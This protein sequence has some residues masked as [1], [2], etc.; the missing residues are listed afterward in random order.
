T[1]VLAGKEWK[2]GKSKQNTFNVNARITMQGGE[3]YAPFDI[4][5]TTVKQQIVYDETKA[6]TKQTAPLM[7]VHLTVAYKKNKLK[8]SREL[9]LKIVNLTQQ[10]DFY[11]YQYNFRTGGIDQ[12][13]ETILLPNLSYKIQF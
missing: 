12:D 10:P 1:N 11:G 4:T 2:I 3:R 5:A 8:S 7:N 9:A 13:V 6:F